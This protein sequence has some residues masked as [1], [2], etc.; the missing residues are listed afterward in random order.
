[1]GISLQL[2]R[3]EKL[4]RGALI[5]FSSPQRRLGPIASFSKARCQLDKC[6]GTSLRWC[7]VEFCIHDLYQ[8]I[9]APAQAGAHRVWQ[10]NTA[11]SVLGG[12][13]A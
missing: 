3:D 1:L 7:D 2:H 8:N 4:A 11:F 6:I 12:E 9:V 5:A 10:F 13:A